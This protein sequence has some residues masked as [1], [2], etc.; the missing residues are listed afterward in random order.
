MLIKC[1]VQIAHL[2]KIGNQLHEITYKRQYINIMNTSYLLLKLE[3]KKCCIN[4]VET[5]YTRMILW[6]CPKHLAVILL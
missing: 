5:V 3:Q 1:I 2:Q 6:S 4:C